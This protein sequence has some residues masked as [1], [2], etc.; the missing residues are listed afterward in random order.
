MVRGI[1]SLLGI[2]MACA[3]LLGLTHQATTV[4]IER[5]QSARFWQQ[6]NELTAIDVPID[7]V[8]W[9][10]NVWHLCNGLALVR[11]ETRG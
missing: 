7:K 9:Q 1:G 5:N 6:V 4:H 11:G 2:A 3:L 10:E 8:E